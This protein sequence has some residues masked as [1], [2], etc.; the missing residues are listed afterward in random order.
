MRQSCSTHFAPSV[1]QAQ[2][3]DQQMAW[4]VLQGTG[5]SVCLLLENCL[6]PYLCMVDVMIRDVMIRP[7]MSHPFVEELHAEY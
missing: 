2:P 1:F 7:A 4:E 5:N 6:L 3:V